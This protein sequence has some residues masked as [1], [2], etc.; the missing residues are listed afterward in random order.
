MGKQFGEGKE[1]AKMRIQ[2]NIERWPLRV[3]K[4]YM[5]NVFVFN[6]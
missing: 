6:N 3:I 5:S 1:K 2:Y 4:V